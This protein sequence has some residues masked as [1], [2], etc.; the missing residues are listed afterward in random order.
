MK[1]VLLMMISVGL[2]A[3]CD[4]PQP[5]PYPTYTPYP[6]STPYPTYTPYPTPVA[7][8]TP[9]ATPIPAPATPTPVPPTP[10]TAATLAPEA[11]PIP[12]LT[13]GQPVTITYIHM[14]DAAIGWAIGGET[15]V[16]D[17]VLRTS[18]GG[19]TW[20]DIT[21][22]ELA[23]TGDDPGKIAI[24]FFPDADTAWVAYSY[25]DFFEVPLVPTVWRTRNGGQTWEPSQP[26]VGDF[27][28]F[29]APSN[30]QFVDTQNGW[31]LVHV[32]AGMMHDYVMLFKTTD[33]G[34][35]WDRVIDPHTDGHLQGC[36]K[37]GMAFVDA[38]TGWVTRDCRGV[39]EGAS[40]DW[41][42]D[43]GLTWQ[44]QQLPP[45]AVYP[46][47]F[48]PPSRCGVYSPTLF[49]PHSGALVLECVR[50]DGAI[51]SHHSFLYVTADAGQSWRSN[52]FPGGSLQF[53]TANVGWALG[54]DIYQTQDGGQPWTH[55]KTVGW[56]GRFHLITDQ[57]G[58]AVARSGDEIALV[59]TTNGGQTWNQL[60]P[61]IVP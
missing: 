43:G 45:P 10:T 44:S 20:A 53:I 13:P 2:L 42:H 56:E 29:Y 18:D 23:P 38:Q 57:A 34:V 47:L 25:L 6:T 61:Q 55:I 58:W 24:G 22:P 49:S 9:T 21:P 35:R 27:V 36:S 7:T 60:K 48:D 5:T 37:T 12:P 52:P 59:Q 39:V 28:E 16:G 32:G 50:Y 31:L 1:K 41:T 8:D 26:L 54:R 40:I 3:A 11:M 51:P 17:H 4:V 33:G 19:H 14:L 46:D 15:E 30:L